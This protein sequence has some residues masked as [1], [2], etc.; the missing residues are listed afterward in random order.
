MPG[1][2]QT[3]LRYGPYSTPLFIRGVRIR[4]EVRGMVRTVALSTGPIPWPLGEA[5]GEQ[6]L[7][8]YRGLARALRSESTTAVADAWGLPLATVNR[9]QRALAIVNDTEAKRRER[10]AAA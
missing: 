1:V 6:E 7:I 9:W 5:N 3:I 4:C 8:V 10:I 2:D